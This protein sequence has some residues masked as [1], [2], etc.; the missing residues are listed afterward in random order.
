MFLLELLELLLLPLVDLLPSRLVCV[1]LLNLLLLLDL[2]LLDPLALLVLSLA[3]LDILLPL[4]LIEL[5]AHRRRRVGVVRPRT[6]RPVIVGPVSTTVCR[7]IPGLIALRQLAVGI[8]GGWPIRIILDVAPRLAG[9]I[10]TRG[11]VRIVSP[12]G[13]RLSRIVGSGRPV[14]IILIIPLLLPLAISFVVLPLA[15][16]IIALAVL[17]RTGGGRRGHPDVRARLFVVAAP[18]L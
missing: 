10:G 4:L 12:I 14:G 6:G 1:S 9:V 8:G 15:G 18:L 5:R 11:L 2:F 3:E 16:P 7:R 17:R 13:L